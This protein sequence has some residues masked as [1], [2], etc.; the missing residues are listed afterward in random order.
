MSSATIHQNSSHSSPFATGN[1]TPVQVQVIHALARGSSVTAAAAEAAIHRTTINHWQRTSTEFRAALNQARQHFTE[2]LADEV[3]DL[4]ALALQTLRNLLADSET[5]D[6]I[7]LRA[8]LA[9]LQRPAFP[10]QGWQLPERI[11]SPREHMVVDGLA[12]LEADY[13]SMRM[14]QALEDEED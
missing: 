2:S 8:A 10:S 6:A 13:H 1:L 7:R 4:S 11:E 9:V 5:N 14:P 3:R 12:E